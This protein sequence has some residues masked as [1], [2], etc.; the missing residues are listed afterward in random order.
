M[1]DFEIKDDVML[2]EMNVLN[3]KKNQDV[4]T[5]LESAWAAQNSWP[6]VRDSSAVHDTQS[7]E[8]MSAS[9]CD[10]LT[11]IFFNTLFVFSLNIKPVRAVYLNKV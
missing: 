10:K 5:L 6:W 4:S 1:L 11:G 9:G 2:V 3:R 7:D 8:N